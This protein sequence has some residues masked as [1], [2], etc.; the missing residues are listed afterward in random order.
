MNDVTISLAPGQSRPISFRL[1]LLRA[2]DRSISLEVRYS[3]YGDNSAPECTTFS[4]DLVERDVRSLHKITFLQ[5]SGTVSHA[6]LKAPTPQSSLDLNESQAL[7]I[8]LFLHG[9]GLEVD[10]PEGRHMLDGLF[11]LPAWFLLP[12][13]GTS[14]CGDDWREQVIVMSVETA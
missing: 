1:Q 6:L 4:Y 2:D 5:P 9:S 8:F 13:G 11:D 10:S 7:P 3:L 14:W 12:T